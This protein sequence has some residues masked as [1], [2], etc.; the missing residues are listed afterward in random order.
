MLTLQTLWRGW[1]DLS[2]N[3]DILTLLEERGGRVEKK[4]NNFCKTFEIIINLT[5]FF[6]HH[7]LLFTIYYL[8][9]P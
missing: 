1:G 7:A 2:Q 8:F 6:L 9:N 4:K 5:N 3:A